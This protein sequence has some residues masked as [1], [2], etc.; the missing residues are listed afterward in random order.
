MHVFVC[1]PQALQGKDVDS[2][3]VCVGGGGML[4][5][6]AAY[7]KALRPE[8]KVIGV[9]ADDAAGTCHPD[10]SVPVFRVLECALIWYTCRLLVLESRSP[11]TEPTAM[12]SLP[13]QL[14][15]LEVFCSSY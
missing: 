10:V 12:Y 7:V 5:G 8:V 6:I 9:E 2:I 14:F 4:A 15:A 13:F 1:V 3:F 11:L